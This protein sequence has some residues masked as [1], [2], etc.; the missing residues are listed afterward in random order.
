VLSARRSR[1]LCSTL[2]GGI[3]SLRRLDSRSC[4]RKPSLKS[5]RDRWPAAASLNSWNWIEAANVPSV[6]L[7]SSGHGTPGPPDTEVQVNHDSLRVLR[8]AHCFVSIGTASSLL[9]CCATTLDRISASVLGH[10]SC[11]ERT[12]YEHALTNENG[13][14]RRPALS[15]RNG[16]RLLRSRPYRRP[17]ME[18]A[19]LS[20]GLS[21]M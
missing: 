16:C 5:T 1:G 17:T 18:G 2:P 4:R 12:T 15:D 3:I 19:P 14:A 11:R 7:P 6:W 8:S 10:R 20:S 13:P 21:A 9:T